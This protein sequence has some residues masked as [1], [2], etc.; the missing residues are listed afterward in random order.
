MDLLPDLTRP[1]VGLKSSCSVIW[2][3]YTPL[4]V[5]IFYDFR[6]LQVEWHRFVVTAGIVLQGTA[7]AEGHYQGI[8]WPS[9][10]ALE[11]EDFRAAMLLGADPEVA[12]TIHLIWIVPSRLTNRLW[13]RPLPKPQRS[14][15]DLLGDRFAQL[16]FWPRAFSRLG[17]MTH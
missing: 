8:L 5:P 3:R 11:C 13:S 4:Q 9:G 16:H 17:V 15:D 12:K 1:A 2:N 10:T 6:G 14:F 7:P